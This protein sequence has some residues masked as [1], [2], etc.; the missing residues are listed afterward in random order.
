MVI[1]IFLAHLVSDYILQC[2]RLARWKSR[3]LKGVLAHGSIVLAVTWLFS[4]PFDAGWWPW[5]LCIGLTH[6]AVDAA[7]LWLS[8]RAPTRKAG[9]FALA[10]YV[11][12][13]A[14]HI[15]IILTALVSS[16]YLAIPSLVADLAF[17][18]HSNRLLTL[19]LGYAF[20]TM[21]A[22]ILVEYAAHG[23]VEGSLP[24]FSPPAKYAGILE[25]GLIT[26]LVMT[27]QFAL[28]PLVAL[29]RLILEGSPVTSRRHTTLYVAELAASVT[30]AIATGLWLRLLQM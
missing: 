21:P 29:P 12:D 6:M 10:R 7:P 2:D 14:V 28:A 26:T 23:L 27:G 3:E 25:R 5:A 9:L 8:R 30:L 1:A 18:L 16:G 4:L 22:W 19:A 13:Q 11:A 24:D 15:G 17:A 20:I